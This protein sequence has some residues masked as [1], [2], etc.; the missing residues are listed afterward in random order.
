MIDGEGDLSE[1]DK[2]KRN[3]A[4]ENHKKW[5]DAAAALGCHAIRVNTGSHYSPTDVASGRRGLRSLA[6]YGSKHK[7]EIICENHGGPSSDPDALLAL[8]KKVGN[9]DFGTLPDFGNFPNKDRRVR[10]D[11]YEAIARMMPYAKGVSAKSYDFKEDGNET[12]LDYAR[13]LKIVTDAGYNG[14]V[15]IEY[16]GSRLSEPEGIMATKKLLESLQALSTRV[17]RSWGPRIRTLFDSIRRWAE[18]RGPRVVFR[19]ATMAFILAVNVGSSSLKFG[20]FTGGDRP[21]RQCSGQISRIGHEG[22]S[23][24]VSHQNGPSESR[25]S[26]LPTISTPLGRCST[27]SNRRSAWRRSRRSGIASST[28][29]RTTSTPCGSPPRVVDDLRAITPLDPN[30]LAGEIAVI[31]AFRHR[32]PES[33]A[34]RVLR[35]G[36]PPRHAPR[37]ADDRHPPAIRGRRGAALR[38]PRPVV[39]VPDGRAGTRGRT[40][41]LAAG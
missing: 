23:W 37:R 27:G 29:A 24:S 18:I 15:G 19:E 31:E 11:V 13:I 17:D 10:I 39:C 33:L 22:S 28:V 35:H 5:V 25:L 38:L 16:E 34:R 7:I 8:I 9:K 20:L 21:D 3:E 26:P 40:P 2:A 32:L 12:H 30:H 14:W 4:V 36:V 41:R 6:E 1:P